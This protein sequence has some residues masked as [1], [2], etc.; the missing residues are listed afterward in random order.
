MNDLNVLA[1]KPVIKLYKEE[2]DMW[3]M[4][5][6]ITAGRDHAADGIPCQD[7]IYMVKD[8]PCT[9]AAL[10]D[11]AGSA[12]HSES[13]AAHAAKTVCT[14]LCSNFDRLYA[15]ED[16]EAVCNE[17]AEIL[18]QAVTDL[19]GR[20]RCPVYD[21]SSTIMAAVI[22]GGK[23]MMMHLGD[24]VMGFIENGQARVASHPVNGEYLNE[25]VFT[26][27]RSA[28]R[29]MQFR[30]GKTERI[31]AFIMMSDGPENCLYD[32]REKQLAGV[33]YNMIKG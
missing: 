2:T 28:G 16:K 15:E 33:L 20:L 24:G 26:T 32:R 25:T 29:Y 23:F 27:S 5:G 3:R 17:L 4:T 7:R 1:E 11:G 18:L 21:L 9:A 30:K 10:A 12:V 14:Y 31:D 6:C 19:A 8:G 22:K 13:G